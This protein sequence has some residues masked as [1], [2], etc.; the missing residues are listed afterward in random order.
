MS[1]P[2]DLFTTIVRIFAAPSI[3]YRVSFL[4]VGLIQFQETRMP[5]RIEHRDGQQF[6][7]CEAIGSNHEMLL[8]SAGIEKSTAELL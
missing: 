2:K 1:Y 7:D 4:F 6:S 3:V 5:D 8:L